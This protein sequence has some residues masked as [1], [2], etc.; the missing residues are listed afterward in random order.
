MFHSDNPRQVRASRELVAVIVV[1]A[2][3][4]GGLLLAMPHGLSVDTDGYR[5]LAE[6]LVQY[7]V[8]GFSPS[9]DSAPPVPTA[10]RPPLYPLLLSTVAL[11]GNLAPV[12][13]GLLHLLLG[14]LTVAVVYLI[15][16]RCRLKE[17][18]WLACLLV[19]CDPI[20][21]NQSVQIMTETLAALLAAVALW[22]LIRLV[23]FPVTWSVSMA[24]RPFRLAYRITVAQFPNVLAATIA[25]VSFGFISANF[26]STRADADWAEDIDGV[27]SV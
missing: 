13:I 23:L 24:F 14:V 21:L 9:D 17:F 11:S 15:A 16:L 4:R 12:G 10:Y 5:S 26:G 18:R 7:G 3:I 2:I 1:A 22:M 25:V 8:Y 27:P 19:A 20:L 6:N